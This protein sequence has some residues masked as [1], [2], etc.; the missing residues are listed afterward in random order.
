MLVN[1]RKIDRPLIHVGDNVWTRENFT[2]WIPRRKK[3]LVPCK[4]KK[5][6]DPIY[7]WKKEAKK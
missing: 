5:N 4:K 1:T 3:K 2:A 7:Y 6:M